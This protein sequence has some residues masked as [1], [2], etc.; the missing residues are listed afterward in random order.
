MAKRKSKSIVSR[1]M[2]KIRKDAWKKVPLEKRIE[3]GR[4]LA[5]ARHH[6]KKKKK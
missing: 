1:A 5:E 4:R 6:P 2:S 3:V